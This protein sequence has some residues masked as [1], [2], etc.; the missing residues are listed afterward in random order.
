MGHLDIQMPDGKHRITTYTSKQDVANQ[1]VLALC[2]N[3]VKEYIPLTDLKKHNYCA[4]V[5]AFGS[6][7]YLIEGSLYFHTVVNLDPDNEYLRIVKLMIDTGNADETVILQYSYDKVTWYDYA[8]IT[9]E[10]P[11]TIQYHPRGAP[12]YYR[13]YY[14]RESGTYYSSVWESMDYSLDFEIPIY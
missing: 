2:R 4:A 1:N 12:K 11:A 14:L 6:K 5:M 9:K 13:L 7:F 10:N 3:G 8:T